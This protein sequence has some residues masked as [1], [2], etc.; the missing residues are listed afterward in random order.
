MTET[1]P[2]AAAADDNP[3]RSGVVENQVLPTDGDSEPER[4]R[5]EHLSHEASLRSVGTLYLLGAG[6]NAIFA[7]AIIAAAF[8]GSIG[9]IEL[10]I[11]AGIV[12][13]GVGLS[14][15][16]GYGLRKLQPWAAIPAGVLSVL[17]LFGFPLGTLISLYVLYLLF[18][19][20]GR[21]ILSPEYA[22]IVSNT[23]H[24]KYKTSVLV[25]IGL[26]LVVAAVGGL[27]A[28]AF[29]AKA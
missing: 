2:F 27:I 23:P 13:V 5:R 1:N 15:V 9:A 21:Y 28:S 18:S 17:G 29:F 10:V 24:I 12:V 4:V 11:F 20:K 25:W 19:Q 14:G 22:A 6:I 26:A 7:I 8:A 16:A 3:Y